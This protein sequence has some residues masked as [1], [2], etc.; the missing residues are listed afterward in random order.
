MAFGKEAEVVVEGLRVEILQ[1]LRRR[2]EQRRN[3]GP[4]VVA[5]VP[6]RAGEAVELEE[7]R[8]SLRNMKP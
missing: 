8:A 2:P 1:Q 5:A 4:L 3:A 6:L 7:G